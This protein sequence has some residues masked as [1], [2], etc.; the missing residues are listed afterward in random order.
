MIAVLLESLVIGFRRMCRYSFWCSIF[1]DAVGFFDNGGVASDLVES[2]AD[3]FWVAV[4]SSVLASDVSHNC[5]QVKVEMD[6]ASLHF[7]FVFV[8]ERV[9]VSDGGT[10]PLE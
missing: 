5:C 10:K 1:E 2:V 8:V 7:V 6:E 4:C 3:G 9:V